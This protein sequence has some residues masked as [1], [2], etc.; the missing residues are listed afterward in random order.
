L[1]GFGGSGRDISRSLIVR[2]GA[3]HAENHDMKLFLK[4]ALLSA[5]FAVAGVAYAAGPTGTGMPTTPPNDTT[6][7]DT[8]TPPDRPTDTNTGTS[9]STTGGSS[10]DTNADTNSNTNTNGNMGSDRSSTMPS[11]HHRMSS[12]ATRHHGSSMHMASSRY[13]EQCSELRSQWQDASMQHRHMRHYTSAKRLAM[14]G[15]H[16]CKM[17]STSSM[18]TGVMHLRSAIRRLGERPS[19]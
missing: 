1:N 16:S 19:I 10:T 8:S 15:E 14:K 6:G 2:Q 11:S 3:I 7:T 4:A 9:G 13:R 12:S 17:R 5:T 18:K